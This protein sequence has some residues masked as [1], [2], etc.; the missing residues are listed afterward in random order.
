MLSSNSCRHI[1]ERIGK[2]GIEKTKTA[3][4]QVN[5]IT[6]EAVSSAARWRDLNASTGITRGGTEVMPNF[7]VPFV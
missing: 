5:F 2:I 1:I 3:F 6:K 7:L 4:K